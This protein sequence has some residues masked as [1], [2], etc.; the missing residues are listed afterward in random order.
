M[1]KLV[2]INVTCNGSTGRIMNQIQQTAENE[3]WEAYSFFGRGKPA[4]EN[5]IKIDSKLEILWHVFITRFF[6]KHGHGSKLATKRMIRKIKKINPDIIHL[7]NIHGYYVNFKIL[8]NYLKKCDKKIVWTLHDCWSFT[9][10]CTYFTMAECNKWKKQC[11]RCVQKNFYP[12]SLFLDSSKNEYYLKKEMFTNVHDL[13]IIT[14]SNWLKELV[15]NSFLKDYEIDVINNGI[16]LNVFKQASSEQI[17]KTKQK[18][19]LEKYNKI[20]LGVA[21]TWDERKGLN[22]IK[23]LAKKINE[24]MIIF[25]VGLSEKQLKELP[26]NIIGI[27]NTEDI[28]ELVTIYSMADILFNPSKEETFSLVTIESIAC[29]TP[30]IAYDNSAIKELINHENGTL[31]D[32][33]KNIESNIE[34]TLEYLKI[35]KKIKYKDINKYRI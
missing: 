28:N 12:R 27:K 21:S 4:N 24:D 7:H 11:D 20:I 25:V 31:L 32:Y 19:N 23:E 15:K 29:G 3:G 22:E 5:C 35:S 30:V 14:P 9:G 26:F 34:K 2:Q 8:F 10:H 6:N 13:K 1:K 18:Y 16:D 33:K 17:Q